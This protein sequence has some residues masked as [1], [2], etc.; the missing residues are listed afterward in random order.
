MPKINPIQASFSGG[1][2][3]PRFRAQTNSDKYANSL[4]F[5]ENF[6]PT[7]YGSLEMR[8]GFQHIGFSQHINPRLFSFERGLSG[9]VIVEIGPAPDGN[10]V[11][12]DRSGVINVPAPQPPQPL[13]DVVEL[14][15]DRAFAAGP[16]NWRRCNRSM[17]R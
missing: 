13:Q 1:E 11:I 10:V 6:V 2:L 5:C 9:D 17:R 4:A 12:W 7:P 16:S 8:S 14:F 15:T 3:S